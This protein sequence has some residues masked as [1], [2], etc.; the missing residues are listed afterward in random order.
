MYLPQ[1]KLPYQ[2][3]HFEIVSFSILERSLYI[4]LTTG[5]FTRVE[6]LRINKFYHRNFRISQLIPWLFL[7]TQLFIIA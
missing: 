7:P 1:L 6:Y 4:L 2:T 3:Y 5:I